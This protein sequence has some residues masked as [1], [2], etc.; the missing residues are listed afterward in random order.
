MMLE[1]VALIVLAIELVIILLLVES[2]RKSRGKVITDFFI[3]LFV[4]GLLIHTAGLLYNLEQGAERVNPLMSA[5]VVLIGSVKIFSF[6][7]NDVLLGAATSASPLFA[8]AVLFTHLLASGFSLFLLWVLFFKSLANNLILFFNRLSSHY[9]ILGQSGQVEMFVEDLKKRGRRRI[10]VVTGSESEEAKKKWLQK[11]V[12]VVN[13][14]LSREALDLAGIISFKKKVTVVSFLET[15]EENLNAA[16]LLSDYLHGKVESERIK[17]LNLVCAIQ[18]QNIIRSEH[19]KFSESLHGKLRFFNVSDLIARDFLIKHPVTKYIPERFFD[20]EGA[21]LVPEASLAQVF[22]GFGST[23]KEMLVKSICNDQMLGQDYQALVIDKDIKDK[24]LEFQHQAR[25]LFGELEPED[26]EY[27]ESPEER[28]KIEFLEANA[29]SKT[30]FD[31][32][33][34]KVKENGFTR[35]FVSLGSDKTN[36]ETAL[37]IRQRLYEAG[38]LERVRIFSLQKKDTFPQGNLDLL[39]KSFPDCPIVFFGSEKAVLTEE[40]LINEKLDGLAKRVAG[41]YQKAR[42][43]EKDEAE[44]WNSLSPFAQ[45]SNRMAAYGIRVKLNLIGLDLSE[46]EEG[47]SEEEYFACYKLSAEEKELLREFGP[48]YVEIFLRDENGRIKDNARNNLARLEHL[49]WN[50]LHLVNGWAK[51]PIADVKVKKPEKEGEKPRLIRKNESLKRHA[52]LTSFEGLD[53]LTGISLEKFK[54]FNLKQDDALKECEAIRY[55]FG[56]MD[57]LYGL[58][59]NSPYRIIKG[60]EK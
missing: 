43:A 36:L 45:E 5:L 10:T 25:G 59:Q 38:L 20:Y 1:T 28:F 52:C 29:L 49:R 2:R 50:A 24:S 34:K 16:L 48:K 21:K 37:E 17:D 60:N 53:R 42:D 51:L 7:Y 54:E 15:D 57:N 26:G 32:I 41:T 39:N 33:R 4:C 19:F 22:V 47:I 9:V 11:G 14:K 35:I 13:R 18:Y 58:L 12:A 8:V 23:N 31:E 27:L 44:V 40:V 3:P 30:F 56:L 46:T 55:D 6:S